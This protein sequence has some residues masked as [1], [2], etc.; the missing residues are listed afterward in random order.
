MRLELASSLGLIDKNKLSFVWVTDFP[1]FEWDSVEK[2]WSAMHHPF[3]APQNEWKELDPSKIYARAYDIVLNGVELGGGS[4]RIHKRDDQER[5]FEILGLDKALSKEMFGFLL[6]AQQLGFPPHGGIALGLDRLIMLLTGSSSIR[7]VI[8]FP[9]TAR[10]HDPLMS[11]P[12][13]V[14]SKKLKDYGLKP[15]K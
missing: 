8:A 14:S 13:S 11:A 1:M 10:G 12:S 2:R 9:K 3:T 4:I 15:L 5:I 7:E 6:E